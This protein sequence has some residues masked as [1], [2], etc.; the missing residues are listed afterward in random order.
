MAL[1]LMHTLLGLRQRRLRKAES[2][3]AVA[4]RDHQK[5]LDGL[6]RSRKTLKKW[7]QDLPKKEQ[8]LFDAVKGKNVQRKG[9]EDMR[10][11]VSALRQHEN[12]LAE[13]CVQAK[14][15]HTAAQENLHQHQHRYQQAQKGK[16]KISQAKAL[17]DKEQHILAQR[18]EDDALDEIATARRR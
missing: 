15:T 3:L 14:K 11:K 2:A 8:R 13:Q 5:A 4:R 6:K 16:E 1:S 7:R 12:D 18:A 17:L 9:L 10:Q